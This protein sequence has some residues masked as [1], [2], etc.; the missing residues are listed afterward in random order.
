MPN[1]E[2]STSHNRL[3]R[4]I[5]VGVSS[6]LITMIIVYSLGLIRPEVLVFML[7]AATKDD[8]S[9]LQTHVVQLDYKLEGVTTSLDDAMADL[10]NQLDRYDESSLT[11]VIASLLNIVT[12]VQE[13]LD[14]LDEPG[15]SFYFATIHLFEKTG[16]TVTQVISY[17]QEANLDNSAG[18]APL[19]INY[20]FER[21]YRY[22]IDELIKSRDVSPQEVRNK[23]VEFY[24]LPPTDPEVEKQTA[25]CQ[26]SIV[27][28][29]GRKAEITIEWTERWAVGIINEGR[30]GSG[31]RLGSYKVFLGYVE[32]CILVDQQ[33]VN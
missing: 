7:G 26:I 29:A 14:N 10:Q 11:D 18:E 32:P 30:D 31:D 13:R 8:L 23:I 16:D 24:K 6:S 28:P 19:L 21:S 4:E 2:S 20:Q 33:N 3:M 5:V 25:I 17:D 15:K 9:E 27:V 1:K 22:E 12:N